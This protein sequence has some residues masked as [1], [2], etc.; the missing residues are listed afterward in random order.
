MPRTWLRLDRPAALALLLAGVL[1]L[2]AALGSPP[3]DT[4]AQ[5]CPP[6]CSTPIVT[7][8]WHLH[9]CDDTYEGQQ[10]DNHCMVGDGVT[11]F[12]HGTNEVFIIYCHR[13][14]DLVV[15]QVHDSGG[16]LQY[17]NHP[18]GI[19]YQG[20]GCDTMKFSRRNG[21]APAGSPYY[22]SAWWPEGPF[23]GVSR[24]IAW[25]IGLF[26]A[27]D[28]EDYY[29]FDAEAQ[30]T[31]RDPGASLDPM[32][33]ETI[34]A[35]VTS[36]SD[37]VGIAVTLREELPGFSL[38]RITRPL[39]FSSEASDE[40]A[41][42]IKVASRD[43]VTVS[44]CP[45]NC[46]KPYEDRARWY[47]LVATVT[48]TNLPTW[49]G[50]TTTPTAT[51]PPDVPVRYAVLRPGA[52][53]VGYAPQST[54]RGLANHLG[55]PSVYAGMWTSGSNRHFGMVQFDLS[56]LPSPAA[57]VSAR[58]EMVG[59]D[60]DFAEPGEWSVK[61]LDKAIDASW[62]SATFAQVSEATVLAQ[63][64]RALGHTDLAE[65]V[66]N[67][68]GFSTEQL[69]L[70]EERLGSTQ[71]ASFRV[72]GPMEP[73]YNLFG[74]HSGVD[75]YRREKVAPDPALR[76][77][78][79]LGYV[80]G[81]GPMPTVTQ[82]AHS[83]TPSPPVPTATRTATEPAG[84]TASA[85]SRPTVSATVTV[86][87]SATVSATATEGA[88]ASVTPTAPDATTPA[89]P[90]P[91]ATGTTS[92]PA[93]S[94]LPSPSGTA[95]T[96]GGTPA[97]QRQV[98]L[99]AFDDADGDGGMGPTERFLPGV[100]VR[101]THVPSA[102]FVSWTTDGRNDPDYCWSGLAD[103]PYVIAVVQV[104]LG[105]VASGPV[106]HDFVVPYQGPPA[107]FRFALRRPDVVPPTPSAA[108]T[109]AKHTPPA[110]APATV[111]P[112]PG[113]STG[114]TD[115]PTRSPTPQPTVTGPSGEVCVAVFDDLDLGGSRGAAEPFL[116][117][118]LVAIQDV[119]RRE[120]RA[121]RTS[122]AGLVCS[123]LAVGPYY[124]RLEPAPLTIH[125]TPQL[126]S[127]QLTDRQRR[128]V[129]FGVARMPARDAVYVPFGSR[130]VR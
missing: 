108:A 99:L 94:V 121:L 3:S 43:T 32:V 18:D 23:T 30:V 76:P 91:S 65:G 125:T 27:F 113:P 68:F 103:G 13:A 64:G 130:F 95:T 79:T 78:L 75:M 61:L 8:A 127:L 63:I 109:D 102:A 34:T 33:Y 9:M 116:D 36:D 111:Q 39:R 67:A 129:E 21:I 86:P 71:R 53:D 114:A 70:L 44:Y 55:Y 128:I 41:G 59:R 92:A 107:V 115:A 12:P 46:A 28:Q 20:N 50:P 37:P 120:V 105:Y 118:H 58:L 10:V 90:P 49:P 56:S 42:V 25:F 54:N 82:G 66:T 85:T 112:T 110:T 29:G 77:S 51:S 104:P 45:R 74:W 48:P 117:G 11:E 40:S 57:I 84:P 1:A 52:D 16:G 98:C 106:T 62:R 15:V 17:V 14:D 6:Y 7:P 80:T 124:V 72:D 100:T 26:I 101:V 87:G 126:V 89:E 93:P 47:Q 19:T 88:G 81:V 24:G 83:P 123:R 4:R 96:A 38:F 31:A 73:G 22:T 5:A 2:L 35:R 69:W 119:G 122:P 97:A 60:G